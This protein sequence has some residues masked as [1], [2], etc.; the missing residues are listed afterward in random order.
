MILFE[1]IGEEIQT[2]YR[3]MVIHTFD[4]KEFNEKLAFQ[5][6]VKILEKHKFVI[7]EIHQ[8]SQ[9]LNGTFCVEKSCFILKNINLKYLKLINI[10][11]KF[12]NA[13]MTW[14]IL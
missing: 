3:N 7:Y 12:A 10:Q 11:I 13:L 6:L 5:K 2:I 14:L 1:G 9:N 4:Y 8:S